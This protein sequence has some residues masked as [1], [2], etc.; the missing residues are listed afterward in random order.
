MERYD[1]SRFE[2]PTISSSSLHTYTKLLPPLPNTEKTK[3]SLLNT[4]TI[5]RKEKLNYELKYENKNSSCI[6][7]SSCR[8]AHIHSI[9]SHSVIHSLNSLQRECMQ[10]THPFSIV[11]F[12]CRTSLLSFILSTQSRYSL[13]FF[14]LL[15]F[16]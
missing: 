2:L 15:V 14:F 10:H 5:T 16:L 7:L 12:R 8:G 13:M 6:I 4:K 11:A 9:V 3:N 1:F